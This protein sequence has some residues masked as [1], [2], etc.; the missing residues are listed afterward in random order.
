LVSTQRWQ[1]ITNHLPPLT[2][3]EPPEMIEGDEEDEEDEG[4]RTE[5]DSEVPNQE[6]VGHA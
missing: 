2:R 6:V 1:K 5:S 3:K 4:E